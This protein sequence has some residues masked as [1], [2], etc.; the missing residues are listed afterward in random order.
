MVELGSG[1][2]VP[3]FEEQL[4]GAVRR[5]GAHGHD[6]VPRRLRRRPSSPASEAEFAVTVKEVKAKELPELDDDL[7]AE[8][9][10]DTLDE[11]R[12]DIRERLAEAQDARDRGRVPR[13]GARRR[14]RRRDGRGARRAGRGARARAVGRRC[15]TR[16][17]TRA[18]RRETYLR[19]A[20][21]DRGGDRSAENREPTPSA[22]AAARGRAGRGRRGRGHRAD[23]GRDARGA[24]ARRRRPSAARPRSCW[25]AC[26]P[27][28]AWTRSR[29]TS[30]SARRS[31]SSPSRRSRSRRAGRAREKLWTPSASPSLAER[32][33]V[34][35]RP[36]PLLDSPE[37][38]G[39]GRRR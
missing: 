16:S 11:L 24:R 15:S 14:R 12:E 34:W 1:R 29:R 6:H 22:G 38:S 32:P 23:R 20:G 25:S 9:G 19:I 2:L 8:A 27:A 18:S 31:T 5:R 4:E 28:A 37:S 10:F 21:R 30:R 33:G 35:T 39:T 36:E 13:G 26:A 3:G 7:A 17:R